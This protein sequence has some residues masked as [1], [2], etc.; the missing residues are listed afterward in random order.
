VIRYLTVL[1]LMAVLWAVLT[2]GPL[3]SWLLG[4]PVVAG[5]AAL[6]LRLG[7][8]SGRTV[9]PWSA[10]VF[11][12]F[13]LVESLRGGWDIARRAVHPALPIDPGQLTYTLRLPPGTPRV[14]FANTVSLLPGT[15][16]LAIGDEV[17]HV[18]A[19]DQGMP[20][21]ANLARLEGRIAALYGL[22]LAGEAES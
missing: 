2:G 22:T 19:V 1:G 16:T 7:P 10:A 4:G 14:L 11:A 18:H 3:Q 15:L 9:R 17:L 21:R 12:V 5:A 13:F 20:I 6:A 8:G